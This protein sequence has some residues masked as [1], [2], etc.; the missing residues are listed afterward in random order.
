MSDTTNI[1]AKLG[2]NVFKESG[3]FHI[4]INPDKAGD[5][6]LITCVNICPAGLY[7]LDEEGSITLSTDGC[8]E[9][10]TCK[11]ICGS[12]VLTWNYPEGASGVQYRFG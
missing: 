1:K 8:L 3:P 9:C 6:R 7:S 10:G 2:L 12:E 11:I 5:P 4:E